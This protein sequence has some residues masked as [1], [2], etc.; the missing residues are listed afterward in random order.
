[1]PCFRHSG[2]LLLW[3][4]LS[5][6]CALATDVGTIGRT[7]PIA[8]PDLLAD[9]EARARSAV[10]SGRWERIAADARRRAIAYVES[11]P[12]VSGLR[13]V[14][15]A[16]T[17][18]FDPTMVLSQD[19]RDQNGGLMY[20]AGTRVNPLDVVTLAES[21][22]L[23]DGRDP[24]QVELAEKLVRERPVKPVLVGGS[25]LDLMRRWGRP[26]YYDQNGRIADRFHLTA[27][28]ALL[29]QD[30]NLMRIQELVP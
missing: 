5:T 20:A 12:P 3:L 27:V 23:F 22:L 2:A 28:P 9:I 15:E 8:E 24:A 11:P 7:Y 13:T 30:G 17:W 6:S 26:V 18:F 4:I 29:T 21:L 19:I 10:A 16:R 1:M 14:A 25:F